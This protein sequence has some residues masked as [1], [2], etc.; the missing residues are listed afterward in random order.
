MLEA[1]P[2]YRETAWDFQPSGDAYDKQL[3]AE[4]KG[5]RMPQ[6]GVVDISIM[7]EGQSRWLAF[8]NGQLDYVNIPQEY[9]PKALVGDK[10]AADLVKQGNRLQRVID[11]DLTYTAFNMKD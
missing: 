11:P 5:K 4:M 6:I 3:I 8:Q 1:N 9:T 10:L 7:E 2:D